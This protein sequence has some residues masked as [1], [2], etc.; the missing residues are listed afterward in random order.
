MGNNFNKEIK[1]PVD[2]AVSLLNN[3]IEIPN[4]KG[5]KNDTIIDF[6]K[7]ELEELNCHPEVFIADSEKY[8]KHPEY[9]PLPEGVEK[10]QKYITGIIKGSG[11]GKSIL[12]FAHLDT[13]DVGDRDLWDTDPFKLVKKGDRLYGL[14]SADA[15]S[16]VAACLI[17]LRVIK[18]MGLKLKGDVKYLGEND[19]DG[20]NTGLLPAFDKGFN[21]DGAIYVHAPESEHGIGEIKTGSVGFL[22]LRITVF[23]KKPP[24][25]EK[26]N[27]GSFSAKDG[28]NAIDKA[29]KIIDA[30]NE[31]ARERDRKFNRDTEK[32]NFNTGFIRGGETAIAV[33]D[34][35]VIEARITFSTNETVKS[36]FKEVKNILQKVIEKDN[37]LKKYPPKLEIAG[38]KANP[39]VISEDENI[40][41]TVKESIKEV[42]NYNIKLFPYHQGSALRFPIIYDQLPTVGFGPKGGNFCAPN[43]WISEEEYIN[44]IRILVNTIIKWCG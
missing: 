31:Y 10:K 9:N 20:G 38:I 39:G 19:K 33:P 29:V 41:Q 43:E 8:I 4:I 27:P 34:R 22:T 1:I 18:E 23:G 26:F 40:V 2:K 32:T 3:L 6:L 35:C 30:L 12:I 42:G 25:R 17:A 5:K 28:V 16:G 14:G 7:R 24:L 11:D 36:I 44:T 13:E 21:A 37:F 15:K